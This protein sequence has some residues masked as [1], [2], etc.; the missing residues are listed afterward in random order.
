MAHRKQIALQEQ[1]M[2][3]TVRPLKKHTP[4]AEPASQNALKS[5]RDFY[6]RRHQSAH[7]VTYS[8]R[9]GPTRSICRA[10]LYDQH[11]T[12]GARGCSPQVDFTV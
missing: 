4:P 3:A 5:A 12:N 2:A 10:R 6:Q 11:I 1:E 9:N 8:H 7:T